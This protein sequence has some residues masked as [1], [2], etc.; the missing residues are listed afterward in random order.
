[1]TPFWPASLRARLMLLVVICTLPPMALVIYTAVERYKTSV[2]YGYYVS[3][4]TNDTVVSRYDSLVSRSR[5]VLSVLAAS[6]AID[7]SEPA[8][9]K[10]LTAL[11]AQMSVYRSLDV[12]SP[13]GVIV[14]STSPLTTRVDLGD[15][16]WFERVAATRQFV[17][18]V[19]ARGRILHVGLLVFSMPRFAKDGSFMGTVDAVASPNVLLPPSDETNLQRYADI[20]VF[21]SNGTALLHYPNGEK[22]NGTNQSG[23]ELFKQISSGKRDVRRILPG[24]DG[25]MR[26]YTSRYIPTD[27]PDTGIYISSGIY[28]GLLENMAFMPL[29][30]D[31]AL[32]SGIALFIL[33]C[34]WWASTL[35][36]SR[37]IQ[38]LLDTLRHLGSGDWRARTGLDSIDGEIGV[39][40]KGVDGMAENLESRIA[41]L[42][43]AEQ[44]REVSEQR[45]VELLE[46]AADGII[47][48]HVNGVL[49]FVNDALCQMLGYRRDEL[50]KLRF[51]HI[52]DESNLWRQRL[53][54]G[55]SLRFEAWMRHREGRDIPVEVSVK[56]LNNGDIQSIQHDI[57]ERLQA[58]QELE[59]SERQY[60]ALVENSMLGILLRRP[61][62]EIIFANQSL[63]RMC[64]YSRSELLDMKIGALVADKSKIERVQ[65]LGVN[66][67]MSFQSSLCHKGGKIIPV[68]VNAL[69]LDT[70]NIQIVLNDVSERIKAEQL[71]AEERNFVFHSIEAL[72]GIFYV[73]NA[74]GKFLRW[75]RQME[76]I[77][78]YD[79]EDMGRI[80]SADI[81][82]PDRR[83]NHWKVVAEILKG[84]G[85]EGETELYCKDG[86][87]IPYFFV[88]RG[89]EWRGQDCVVGMGVDMTER[90]Q[91]EQLAMKYMNELQQLSARILDA[92]EEERRGLAR[93]LHD[94]LGQGLTA[95]LLS[96][97]NLEEKAGTQTLVAQ[98]RH[99]SGIITELTQQVRAMSLSLRPSVLDD[100]GLVAAI[101]WY[102]RERVES[103]GLRVALSVDRNLPRLTTVKET[104]CFRV[105]QGVLTNV[106]RHANAGMVRVALHR[107]EGNL[108]LDIHDDGRGFDVEAARKAALDGKSLGILGMEERVRLVGGTF[109]IASQAGKGTQVHIEIPLA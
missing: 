44:A 75:N 101:R 84:N 23:S 94:E 3:K 51:T 7:A 38:P 26:L 95:T 87:R 35:F 93:E 82:P 25:K 11:L 43:A 29:L 62:G 24:L 66:E 55:E 16:G 36:V 68:D 80:T 97:K 13:A 91:A 19:V 96:L 10:H 4:L 69:R 33:I 86:R 48:R 106:Q 61:T 81:L 99:A 42:Y 92:Q 22:L 90:I 74:K 37:R 18:G 76:Q 2:D 54:V 12:H 9:A 50:L 53:Q 1:M 34:T 89:F 8:C 41:A 58:R 102:I 49:V 73:F 39:I 45:F 77:T 56:R 27:V 5:D 78:G 79:A 105:L 17:A 71:Y 46:Q 21:T 63:C 103:A 64:G 72:P 88:A 108:V 30:R 28:Q 52:V 83:A 15:R 107:F 70:L 104:A 85:V 20:T 6:S 60:R 59:N 14:C 65:N 67:S 47:V 98:V 100:L 57:S 109:E 31:L 40:A 32:I